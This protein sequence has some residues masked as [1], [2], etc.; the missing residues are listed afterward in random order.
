VPDAPIISGA[1]GGVSI[2]GGVGFT[3]GFGTTSTQ[4]DTQASDPAPE[5]LFELLSLDPAQLDATAEET[6][7]TDSPESDEIAA[8]WF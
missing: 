7:E 6:K 1:S 2:M 8:Q 4:A 3:Q 5:N